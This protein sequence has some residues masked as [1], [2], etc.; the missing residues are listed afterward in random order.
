[1]RPHINL[2]EFSLRTEE[3]LVELDR[4]WDLDRHQRTLSADVEGET[5]HEEISEA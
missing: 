5:S 3:V 1:M 2:E 4:R